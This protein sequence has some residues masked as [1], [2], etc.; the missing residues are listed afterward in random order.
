MAIVV[1]RRYYFLVKTRAKPADLVLLEDL[2]WQLKQLSSSAQIR[3]SEL[4]STAFRL[5]HEVFERALI[6]DNSQT[7]V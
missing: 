6:H 2:F 3:P 7:G 1:R 4:S 5:N